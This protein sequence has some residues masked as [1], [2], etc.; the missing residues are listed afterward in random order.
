MMSLGSSSKGRSLPPGEEERKK[1]LRQMKVRTTLKGDKSWINKQEETESRTM[2]LPSNGRHSSSSSPPITPRSNRGMFTQPEVTSS[3][4]PAPD[5]DCSKRPPNA[6]A[7]TGYIIRGVFTKTIDNTTQPQ[8]YLPNSN[9][10]Q[11]RAAVQ[12]KM[13]SLP[14]QSNSGYKM[15]TEDYKKLAPY[16]VRR[17]SIDTD[18]EESPFSS[19]EQK[20]RSEAA[21]SVVRKA[22][23]RERS[24]V[25]SAAKKSTGSPTQDVPPPFLAKRVEIVEEE[26]PSERSQS[27]PASARPSSGLTRVQGGRNQT[28]STGETETTSKSPVPTSRSLDRREELEN[29]TP[30]PQPRTESNPRAIPTPE[31]REE[32]VRKSPEP[33]PRTETKPRAPQTAEKSENEKEE[34]AELISWSDVIVPRVNQSP[35]TSSVGRIEKSPEPQPRNEEE[36]KAS[37]PGRSEKR[38][39]TP[40]PAWRTTPPDQKVEIPRIVISPEISQKSR[41]NSQTRESTEVT[42]ENQDELSGPKE[43]AGFAPKRPAQG[44]EENTVPRTRET[45]GEMP[46][47]VD[48]KDAYPDVDRSSTWSTDSNHGST[49]SQ[50]EDLDEVES[51]P[52]KGS[53]PNYS[54]TNI[55]SNREIS[56]NRETGS[57]SSRTVEKDELHGTR[58]D[59]HYRES[60]VTETR[61]DHSPVGEHREPYWN[62]ANKVNS[63][64]SCITSPDD[65]YGRPF[66]LQFYKPGPNSASTSTL[67]VTT[68]ETRYGGPP[69]GDDS[70][71]DPTRTPT[72]YGEKSVTV[73][74]RETRLDAPLAGNRPDPTASDPHFRECSVTATDPTRRGSPQPGNLDPSARSREIL[75]VKE[76]TN[77]SELS[78]GKP[79]SSQYSSTS[80]LDDWSAIERSTSSSYQYSA[81]PQRASDGTCT[82]C[83][84]EIRDCPKITLQHLG[85][86]CHDY[87]FK[88]GICH[89]PMGDLLDQIFIHRDTVHCQK[90]Y[91]KLF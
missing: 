13:A 30:E 49:G 76:Y 48:L 17:S 5:S 61:R 78:R 19:E 83:G 77:T 72:S 55:T 79:S 91:E 66:D 63:D 85:I 22:A 16:N 4:Q 56:S 52:R 47:E 38:E 29:R 25:L 33:Q 40:T 58:S 1:I 14:R 37:S 62:L 41:S 8:Q 27:S 65:Q 64:E 21:S 82:Y 44:S 9:G 28:S 51:N 71:S 3:A 46:S 39:E 84:R 50:N 7:P 12:A 68:T 24:Y 15:T 11:K 87:C 80:S 90:C 35:S 67:P 53:I 59:L 42:R 10:V 60:C 75:F 54:D 73:T 31:K 81:P 18:E 86:C 70:N 23:S 32:A 57:E 69:N 26:G 36:P 2:E 74:S 6:K 88:C 20:R 89:K 45:R 43:E 34:E